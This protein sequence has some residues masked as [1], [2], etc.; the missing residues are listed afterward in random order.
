MVGMKLLELVRLL[1]V[2]RLVEM[3]LELGVLGVLRVMIPMLLVLVVVVLVLRVLLVGVMPMRRLLSR[4]SIQ[5]S[6]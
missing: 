2:V 1:V 5:N 6:N 4:V 3:R